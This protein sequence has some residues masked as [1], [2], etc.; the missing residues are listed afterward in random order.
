MLCV[1]QGIAPFGEDIALLTYILDGD[2]NQQE[3]QDGEDQTWVGDAQRPEVRPMSQCLPMLTR[4][5][6]IAVL[7]LQCV[8]QPKTSSSAYYICFRRYEFQR[9]SSS[10]IQS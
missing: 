8:S 5:A 10:L 2:A 7:L 6:T 4:P 1:S 3:M 9:W